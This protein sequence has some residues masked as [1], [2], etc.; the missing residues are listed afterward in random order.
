MKNKSA[1]KRGGPK[2]PMNAGSAF[3]VNKGPSSGIG[4]A[5]QPGTSG[6]KMG[7]IGAA[8]KS[9]SKMGGIGAAMKSGSK[10]GG[11]GGKKQGYMDG[12]MVKGGGKAC[13]TY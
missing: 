1:I 11:M 9:G 13:K 8:M 12:G 7:G 2:P 6:S 3:R 5:M 10:M 4:A